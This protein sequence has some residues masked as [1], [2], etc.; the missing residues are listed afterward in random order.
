MRA[1]SSEY[2]RR[3][4]LPGNV[5]RR[6]DVTSAGGPLGMRLE[7]DEAGVVVVKAVGACFRPRRLQPAPVPAASS[8]L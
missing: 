3:V 4:Q 8:G 2:D 7:C 5:V 1:G 6:I